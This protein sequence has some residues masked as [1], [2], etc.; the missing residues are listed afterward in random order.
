MHKCP[1][2]WEQMVWKQSPFI[3]TDGESQQKHTSLAVESLS[4]GDT[5]SFIAD[6]AL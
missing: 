3:D 5:F 4:W 1:V 2:Q 6:E